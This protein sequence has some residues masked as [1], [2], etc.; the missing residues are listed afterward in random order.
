MSFF[1]LSFPVRPFFLDVS[2]RDNITGI[3]GQYNQYKP[4][5]VLSAPQSAFMQRDSGG[6]CARV[7][8]Y[9][10]TCLLVCVSANVYGCIAHVYVYICIC[11]VYIHI[12][13]RLHYTF[14]R[15]VLACVRLVYWLVRLWSRC[16]DCCRC[17]RHTQTNPVLC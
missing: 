7:S 15:I 1:G 3:E 9:C 5:V 2:C 16:A 8:I 6:A 11:R 13:A 4:E 14:A 12:I 17:R 10:R